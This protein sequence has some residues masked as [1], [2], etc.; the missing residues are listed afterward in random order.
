MHVQVDVLVL[1]SCAHLWI[2]MHAQP[3]T[4]TLQTRN[5]ISNGGCRWFPTAEITIFPP[6]DKYTSV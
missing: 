1:L 5:N 4:E 3:H 2:Y 6:P